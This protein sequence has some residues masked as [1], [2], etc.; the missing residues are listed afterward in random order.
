MA[1]NNDFGKKAEDEAVKFLIQ[2]DFYI[3]ERNWRYGKAEIDIIAKKENKIH[4]IEVKARTSEKVTSPEEAIN[5]KK[6]KLILSATDAYTSIFDEDLDVQF[7]VI[8]ILYINEHFHLKYI[9]DAFNIV[10]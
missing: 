6:I 5:S 1:H 7:D 8:S 2:N 9:E 3:M 10:N 4:I